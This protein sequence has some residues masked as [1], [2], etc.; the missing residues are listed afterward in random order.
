VDVKNSYTKERTGD[1]LLKYLKT[2][3]YNINKR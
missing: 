1:F 3:N 2:G